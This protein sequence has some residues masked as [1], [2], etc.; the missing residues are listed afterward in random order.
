[1]NVIYLQREGTDLVLVLVLGDTENE[2]ENED[3]QTVAVILP[4]LLAAEE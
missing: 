3:G 1:M 2:N 4:E